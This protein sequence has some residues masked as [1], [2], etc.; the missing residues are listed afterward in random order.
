M[1]AIRLFPVILSFFILAAHFYRA[2]HNV[3]VITCI[4]M[5]FL[6]FVKKPLSVR[7]LQ[8]ALIAGSVEW[9]R[10]MFVFIEIR[11][12]FGMPYARLAIILGAVAAV[13]A[14]SALVFQS[15]PMKKLYKLDKKEETT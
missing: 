11:Q 8:I 7:I 3:L 9:L 2:G 1:N 10:S 14:L 13:T 4:V 6:L 12:Q 5:P 15:R